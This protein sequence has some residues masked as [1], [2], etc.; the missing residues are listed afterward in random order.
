[1][2]AGAG[3]FAH[4]VETL[5]RRT[6]GEVGGHAA[7]QV[8]G[9][10]H[11]GEVLDRGIEARLQARLMDVGEALREAAVSDPGCV[12]EHMGCAAPLHHGVYRA[13][14]DVAGCEIRER[15]EIRH[16]GSA[17]EIPQHA[18]LATDGLGDQGPPA[19]RS[20]ERRGMELDHLHVPHL[21]AGAVGHGHAVTGGD[22]R[23]RRELVDLAQA[24][25]GEDD[26]LGRHRRDDPL[27]RVEHVDAEHPVLRPAHLDRG[28]EFGARDEVDRQVMLEHPDARGVGDRTEQGGFDG[29]TG[30]V[31]GM[32]DAPARMPALAAEVRTAVGPVF[33][34]HAPRDQLGHP[35]RT[36]FDDV[37]DHV[38]VAK[39]VAGRQRVLHVALEVVGAVGDA[40][41]AALS[42]VGVGFGP[43]LLGDD[44]DAH[45][46]AGQR[47]R[48]AQAADAA[49]HHDGVESFTHV[50]RWKLAPVPRATSA[51]LT[52]Q[53]RG[54]T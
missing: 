29:T 38:D 27:A 37:A 43:C 1:M 7:A 26:H 41:D 17:V 11:H 13:G 4:R 51:Y 39:A 32:K 6:A 30:H 28:V 50:K 5:E 25:G 24:S 19:V 2:Q 46:P 20:L 47:E 53:G 8:V 14:D 54:P 23:I 49:S 36:L 16:E 12:K 3:H 31:P 22:V 44:G 34:L 21:R 45:A 48:E 9:R 10:R 35:G 15:M 52:E 18:A 42:P 40:G 33:K